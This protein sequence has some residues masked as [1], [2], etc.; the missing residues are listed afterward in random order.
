MFAIINIPKN[1]NPERIGLWAQE[2]PDWG[3]EVQALSRT[4]EFASFSDSVKFL[5]LF[6][7][8]TEGVDVTPDVGISGNCVFVRISREDGAPLREIDFQ[9]AADLQEAAG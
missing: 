8:L 5:K 9:I 4:F 7:E 1:M 3:F 6:E 2:L